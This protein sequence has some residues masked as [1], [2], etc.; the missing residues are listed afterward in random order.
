VAEH[1]SIL[2]NKLAIRILVISKIGLC[3]AIS[4]KRSQRE[5]S[6]DVA[7]LR[8]VLKNYQYTHYPRFSFTLKTGIAHPK[9]GVL[10][11][12]CLVA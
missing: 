2:K 10:F 5:L 7:E 12:L 3:S 6:I 8:P 4:F 11:S 9:T 1:S